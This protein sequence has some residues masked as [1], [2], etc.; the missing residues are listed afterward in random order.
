[1]LRML[2]YNWLCIEHKFFFLPKFG[3]CGV[4]VFVLEAESQKAVRIKNSD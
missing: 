4:N 3:R 1:M 2:Y